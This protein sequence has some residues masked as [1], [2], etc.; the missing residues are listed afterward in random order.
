MFISC[1]KVVSP[2]TDSVVDLIDIGVLLVPISIVDAVVK[3]VHNSLDVFTL[4]FLAF[5]VLQ[6]NA[7]LTVASALN[8]VELLKVFEPLIF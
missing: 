4:G 8:V 6:I 2:S 1:E 3:F 7:V 5:I